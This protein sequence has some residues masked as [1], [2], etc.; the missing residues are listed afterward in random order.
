MKD[1]PLQ[2]TYHTYPITGSHESTHTV[3]HPF[4]SASLTHSIFQSSQGYTHTHFSLPIIMYPPTRPASSNTPFSGL[5]LCVNTHPLHMPPTHKHTHTR[6]HTRSP[7]HTH[8]R[9]Q[10]CFH[11]A[12]SNAHHTLTQMHSCAHT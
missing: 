3:V 10:S 12:P 1:P 6:A 5:L 4:R 2:N 11:N 8:T 9:T 7:T